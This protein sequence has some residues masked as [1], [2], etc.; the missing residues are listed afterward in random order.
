MA[1]ILTAICPN[2]LLL[3]IKFREQF[4]G[5]SVACLFVGLLLAIA[6][7]ECAAG[8][9]VAKRQVLAK[10]DAAVSLLAPVTEP[11]GNS[12]KAWPD[13][14]ERV[15][16]NTVSEGPAATELLCETIAR[17]ADA[18][19]LPVEFFASLIWKE[20]RL[21]PQAL[22]PRGAKGIAQ[23]M[24]RTATW[25]GLVDPF[26]PQQAL[27]ESARWLRELRA[28]FGN[29][30][31]AAAAYNAGPNRLRNWLDGSGTLPS[32]TEGYVLVITGRTVEEWNGALHADLENF[33]AREINPCSEIAVTT[34][35]VAPPIPFR[36]PATTEVLT[37]APW[38]L[39]LFG[40][41]SEARAL[42]TY[43]SLQKKHASILGSRPPL[44]LRTR[45]ARGSI[46]WVRIRVAESTREGA[47]QLC[48]QLTARGGSCLVVRN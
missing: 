10:P 16:K 18:H 44:I 38:G 2:R 14:I 48:A 21:D 35:T 29:W 23:F 47:M 45:G 32:E 30:G 31:L 25:R 27:R 42:T 28:E 12:P 9:E 6:S 26:E 19:E 39:Q 36:R 17:E 22:S 7:G 8:D 24:Q 15:L 46:N 41:S 13:E 1:E 5:L 11:Q 40:D 4:S 43:K 37:T 34:A 3:S 20:S 33:A